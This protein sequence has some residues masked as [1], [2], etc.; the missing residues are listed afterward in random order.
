MN[1]DHLLN[2]VHAFDSMKT[3]NFQRILVLGAGEVLEYDTPAALLAD[4]DSVFSS[5][6]LEHAGATH[7][8]PNTTTNAH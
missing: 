6:I 1:L 2:S 3:F 4:K 8:H 5:M 7:T